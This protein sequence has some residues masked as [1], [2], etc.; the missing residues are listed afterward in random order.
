[1]VQTDGAGNGALPSKVHLRIRRQASPTEPARWEEFELPFRQG[2]NVIVCLQDVARHPVTRDGA[3][4]T[5]VAHQASCLEEVCGS[6]TMLING[7][8]RLACSALVQQLPQPITVAPLTKFPL[9]RDLVVDRSAIFEAFKRVRAWVPVDGTYD[10]G[11]GPRVA[12]ETQEKA[13]PLSRCIACC[14]CMEVCPQYNDQTRF[15]GAAAINQARLH[16]LHPTGAMHR[17]ERLRGLMGP[18]GIQACGNA[19]NCVKACPKEIPLT[20]SIA[21]MFRETTRELVR[22]WLGR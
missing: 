21:D 7:R 11:P 2:M 18:G 19:R 5:P 8:A 17:R 9:I 4:T 12:P 16:G 10:I 3:R 13:Y 1:M 15:I 14:A 6:C 22:G 20:E